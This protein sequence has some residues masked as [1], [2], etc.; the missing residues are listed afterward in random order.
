MTPAVSDGER[1]TIVVAPIATRRLS[2]ARLG[3]RS[4]PLLHNKGTRLT[5]LVPLGLKLMQPR[6]SAWLSRMAMLIVRLEN[7]GG[8]ETG[9]PPM[10]AK[11]TFGSLS[12]VG[13]GL[14]KTAKPST[15]GDLAIAAPKRD[16]KSVV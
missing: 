4:E 2:S 16:R 5:T 8:A 7:L 3:K 14:A 15:V 1:T 12:V 13:E 9:F 11:P 6:P 10:K